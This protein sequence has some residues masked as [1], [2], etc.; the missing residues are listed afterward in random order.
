M[1]LVIGRSNRSGHGD[2]DRRTG[3]EYRE[4]FP[5][6]EAGMVGNF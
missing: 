1:A 6:I 2:G 5:N 3:R 4:K